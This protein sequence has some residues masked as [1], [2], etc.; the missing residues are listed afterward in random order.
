M[1]PDFEIRP[2]VAAEPTKPRFQYAEVLPTIKRSLNLKH[3]AIRMQK[4]SFLCWDVADVHHS[5]N[6]KPHTLL[7]FS[8]FS[9]KY[10]LKSSH[11]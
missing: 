3:C 11:L 4:N 10:F 8:N 6:D 7:Y 1:R 2:N 5:K 9:V